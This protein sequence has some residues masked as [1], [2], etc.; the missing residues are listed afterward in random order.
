MPNLRKL[1]VDLN[2]K[3][4]AFAYQTEAFHSLKDP[5]YAAIFHEQGLGKTKIA[6]DLSLYWLEENL[7]DTRFE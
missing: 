4:E 7:L 5:D 6:I 2:P 1:K 3:L